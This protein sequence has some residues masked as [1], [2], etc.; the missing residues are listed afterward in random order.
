MLQKSICFWNGAWN[1][2]MAIELGQRPCIEIWAW[3]I[4]PLS[5][6]ADYRISLIGLDAYRAP[7]LAWWRAADSHMSTS[8]LLLRSLPSGE[9]QFSNKNKRGFLKVFE[10]CIL[11]TQ[12]D[13]AFFTS[14]Q[15]K[16]GGPSTGLNS[17][18]SHEIEDQER[19][20]YCKRS[21]ALNRGL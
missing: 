17:G 19:G 7:V 4:H 11:K 9:I 3:L 13:R 20:I 14:R 10:F 18:T 6:K 12:K 21:L 8:V 15:R 5:W 1:S 16:F 2:T